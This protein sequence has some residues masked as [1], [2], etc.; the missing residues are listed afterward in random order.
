MLVF[1][2]RRAWR[3]ACERDKFE[4]DDSFAGTVCV[5]NNRSYPLK[6]FVIAF[7]HDQKINRQEF[8][9]GCV[10]PAS[11]LRLQTCRTYISKQIKVLSPILR[12]ISSLWFQPIWKISVKLDHSPNRVW[13]W[14]LFE[15]TTWILDIFDE[16]RVLILSSR[17][18]TRPFSCREEHQ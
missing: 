17:P 13:K 10:G 11:I 16:D 9:R 1:F 8:E 3:V 12:Y 14:H 5:Y 18:V 15:T 6:I 4:S 7:P 2:F